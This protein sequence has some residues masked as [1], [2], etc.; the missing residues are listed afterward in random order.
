MTDF[1]VRVELHGATGG[2]YELLHQR[3]I[4]AGFF[5][6]ITASDGRTLRLPT[7]EYH[8]ILPDTTTAENVRAI[9]FTIASA[10]KTGPWVLAMKA[11]DWSLI[12]QVVA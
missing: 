6:A 11:I 8:V 1:F 3:M 4:A 12:S 5:R 9:A 7:A 2:D 10:I